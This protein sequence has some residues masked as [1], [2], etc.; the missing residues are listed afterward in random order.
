VAPIV[1]GRDSYIAAGSVVTDAV[2][3]DAVAFGRARQ[4]N[5]EGYAKAVREKN[6]ARAGKKPK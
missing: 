4:Q 3:A 6:A 2:P 1:L 5:K